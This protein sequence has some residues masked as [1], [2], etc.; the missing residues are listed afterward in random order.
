MSVNSVNSSACHLCKVWE[1]GT[2]KA[3]DF[4]SKNSMD[5]RSY[6]KIGAAD[7]RFEKIT[8][9]ALT[10]LALVTLG[11][12]SLLKVGVETLKAKISTMLPSQRAAEPADTSDK[13][14]KIQ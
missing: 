6:V 2:D 13:E 5:V 10:C 14:K 7:T 1:D 9:V 11:T 3:I 12:F 8:K 4:I